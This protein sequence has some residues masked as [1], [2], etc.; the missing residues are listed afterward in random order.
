MYLHS[1]AR[2]DTCI[3]SV[4]LYT[5][6]HTHTHLDFSP[7]ACSFVLL[8]LFFFYRYTFCWLLY[9][10]TH[11]HAH[12]VCCVHT[13]AHAH[14]YIYTYTHLHTRMT[15]LSSAPHARYFHCA[16]RSGCFSLPLRTRNSPLTCPR[17]LFLPHFF[18]L[19]DALPSSTELLHAFGSCFPPRFFHTF[20][21][22]SSR[23]QLVY[24]YLDR[25][26]S[27]R[28][29][30]YIFKATHLLSFFPGSA[31]FSSSK[32]RSRC[33][34][35][36]GSFLLRVVL[37]LM[38]CS[39]SWCCRSGCALVLLHDEHDRLHNDCFL[40]TNLRIQCVICCVV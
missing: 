5:C 4:S 37:S 33:F 26:R 3:R 25:V 6:T 36:A 10:S 18:N 1:C 27:R 9:A 31:P 14:C 20:L 13:L 21:H 38:F 29:T 24:L 12:H 19:R 11:V 15:A 39:M 17:A 7:S 35:F 22:Q 16:V 8:L 40:R 23:S 30:P 34:C 32:F 2:C 28:T